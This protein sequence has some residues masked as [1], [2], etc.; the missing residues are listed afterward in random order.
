M[1]MVVWL[2][3]AAVSFLCGFFYGI[4]RDPKGPGKE[5]LIRDF[6]V[7]SILEKE[8]ENFLNYDGSEQI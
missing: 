6:T 5:K 2:L 3:L 1:T 7:S 8:Y 4:I